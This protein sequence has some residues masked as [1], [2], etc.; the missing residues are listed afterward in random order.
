MVLVACIAVLLQYATSINKKLGYFLFFNGC[1]RV[2]ITININVYDF[3]HHTTLVCRESFGTY[4]Y[5][6]MVVVIKINHKYLSYVCGIR[7]QRYT[8]IWHSRKIN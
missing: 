4:A 1:S 2:R 8:E 5:I 7:T 6:C 3:I